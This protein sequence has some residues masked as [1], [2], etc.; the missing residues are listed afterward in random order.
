MTH[1]SF[2]ITAFGLRIAGCIKEKIWHESQEIH[3]Q[4]DGSIIFEAQV[5]GTDEI[6]FWIMTWGSKAKVLEPESLWQEIREEAEEMAKGYLESVMAEESH[7]YG[8]TKD[9]LLQRR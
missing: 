1:P 2:P 6:R 7:S 4:P 3:T 9:Q 5:A 8:P